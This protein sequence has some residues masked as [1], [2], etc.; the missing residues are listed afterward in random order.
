MYDNI[1]T[2]YKNTKIFISEATAPTVIK[3]L[4]SEEAQ[5]E[6]TAE[7]YAYLSKG[8]IF[9]G[10]DDMAF[11]YARKSIRADR[12]YPYGYIR[13]AFCYARA[14][15]KKA[16]LKFI[17]MAEKLNIDNNIFLKAF[18]GALYFYCDKKDITEKIV[19]ECKKTCIKNA[20]FY[21]DIGF[22]YSQ[23][24]PELA[25]EY[26][27]KAEELGY[28]DK[29]NLWTNI[30]ENYKALDDY[31]NAEKYA[32]KGLKYGNT[33]KF[34]NIKAEILNKKEQY[35]ESTKRYK[36]LYKLVKDNEDEKSLTF[37]KIIYNYSL[38]NEFD[39]CKRYLDFAFKHFKI[40]DAINIVATNLY[41]RIGEYEK[42]IKTYERMI[43]Q[44]DTNSSW[45]SSLSYCYSQINNNV[46]ALNYVDKALELD[47]ED[48]YSHYRKGRIYTDMKEYE[49]AI[50][51]FMDSIDYDKTDVDSFQ[52]VSYCY[53]MIN[54]FEKSLEFANR[55]ILI[56]PND[57]YSYF[58]KAWAYQEMGRY[59]EAIK[60]YEECINLDDKYIDAYLNI[61]YIYSQ[62]KDMKQSLLYAN[63][64]LLINKDY[65]YAHYRKAWALQETGKFE[66]AYD[67]YSKAIAL[68]PTDIYNYLGI[69]CIA[70]NNNES[71]DALLYANKAI[72]IDRNCGGAYYYKSVALSNLG[73]QKEAEKAYAK[74]VKLGYFPG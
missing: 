70:L 39:R 40:L 12:T 62:M 14:G 42:A 16:V 67:G 53:S 57:S 68:D 20:E 19:E 35:D 9:C 23:E 37:A 5:G 33:I 28:K 52:W 50:K 72:F 11:K 27:L 73:K 15:K 46:Q 48:S 66:E 6:M 74:A 25:L 4:L 69:A 59:K 18:L 36:Q 8:Y 44:D 26:L 31:N 49:L 7:K 41:E 56:N 1:N 24:I 38:K 2:Y 21:Y 10:K 22:I 60:Y 17:K 51:S 3:L 34:L 45:F 64:A 58:R 65:A 54:Q 43:K 61:S 13:L 55:A 32:D 47:P 63:K 71:Y 29:I 30:A